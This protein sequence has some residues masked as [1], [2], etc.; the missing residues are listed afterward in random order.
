MFVVATMMCM[1]VIDRS[2]KD[3]RAQRT[4]SMLERDEIKFDSD[5]DMGNI[6]MDKHSIC[7]AK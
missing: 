4:L 7:F 6:L 3:M 5:L 1:E 2:V